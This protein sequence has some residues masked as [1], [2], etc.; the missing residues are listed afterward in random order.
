MVNITSNI[1]VAD[2]CD[3]TPSVVLL[4][5][6]MN[7]GDETKGDGHTSNDIQVDEGGRIYLRAE[8]SG[9]GN[10]RVYSIKYTATDISGNNT[11]T[12]SVVTVPHNQ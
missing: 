9:A 12:L 5:I 6:T 3:A 1:R 4:S 10:G 2:I 8:R 7:E 11:S